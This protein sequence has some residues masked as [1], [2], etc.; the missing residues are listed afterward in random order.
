V[1][2]CRESGNF[3][4]EVNDI[5]S[6]RC[7]GRYRTIRLNLIVALVAE[8]P[9]EKVRMPE[10][11]VASAIVTRAQRVHLNISGFA[12]Q[13]LSRPVRAIGQALHTGQATSMR[14]AVTTAPNLLQ[15]CLH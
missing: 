10:G 14:S 5:A 9:G 15:R 8:M 3:D 6:S 12:R 1:K 11:E 4:P 13:W 7:H 2:F